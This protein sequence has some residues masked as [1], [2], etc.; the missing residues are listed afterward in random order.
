[1]YEYLKVPKI[2]IIRIEKIVWPIDKYS[3]DMLISGQELRS[4]RKIDL[5]VN[6]ID[7]PIL[8]KLKIKKDSILK[9]ETI[10]EIKYRDRY[11]IETIKIKYSRI[12]SNLDT[13]VRSGQNGYVQ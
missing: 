11:Q 7:Y 1:M 12:D 3:R 9:I 8:K 5:L 13:F 4:Q 6:S 2:Y 10:K